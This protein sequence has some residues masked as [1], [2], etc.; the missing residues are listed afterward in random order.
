MSTD[1]V[2]DW[3]VQDEID[4]LQEQ[5]EAVALGVD[6]VIDA[7]FDDDRVEMHMRCL[8]HHQVK[9]S[10]L[11]RA[12][13]HELEKIDL[14][15]RAATKTLDSSIRYHTENLLAF[16]RSLGETY[17][18]LNGKVKRTAGRMRVLCEDDADKEKFFAWC[19]EMKRLDDLTRVKPEVREP[20]KPAIAKFIKEEGGELPPGIDTETG[21]DSYKIELEIPGQ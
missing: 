11:E 1:N 20:D 14:K 16:G 3:L 12:R 6:P 19:A 5:Y 17:K 15:F 21:E 10:T 2:L 4:A 7:E 13:D 9:R 8:G 18:G